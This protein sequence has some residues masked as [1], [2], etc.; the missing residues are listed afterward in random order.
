MTTLRPRRR[1]HTPSRTATPGP[2]GHRP[3]RQ[4]RLPHGFGRDRRAHHRRPQRDHRLH[5]NLGS[6]GTNCAPTSVVSAA[7]AFRT[8]RRRH[9]AQRRL[10]AP[11]AYRRLKAVIAP[12]TPRWSLATSKPR[13]RSPGM[14]ALLQ[15]GTMNNVTFGEAAPVLKTVG[16]GSGAGDPGATGSVVQTHMTNSRPEVGGAT[17]CCREVRRTS[18]A[19]GAPVAG[20]A[21]TALRRL[22]LPSFIDGQ[23]P[24]QS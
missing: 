10:P 4:R 11:V 9:P 6:A 1:L 18:R 22:E 21:A 13:R 2:Q 20:G 8:G 14:F 12:S 19:A 24:L 5:R 15:A 16:S 17:C 23:H 3:A 7:Y